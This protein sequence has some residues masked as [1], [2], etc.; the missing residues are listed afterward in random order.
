MPTKPFAT[1]QSPSD[2]TS[3]T[4][5]LMA[6]RIMT[7]NPDP[8]KK[9]VPIEKQ[10]YDFVRHEMLNL[11]QEKGPLGAMQIVR[12]MDERLGGDKK[13]G[14]SI[15]WYTTAIRLDLEAR[16]ELMYDRS[17]KKPVVTLPT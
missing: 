2:E 9:G 1:L 7:L 16:G 14:Y 5:R 15:G 6:D 8:S 3:G 11:L 10:R 4:I 13:V 17:A 12:E